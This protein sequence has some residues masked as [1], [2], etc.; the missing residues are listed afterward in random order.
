MAFLQD[1]HNVFYASESITNLSLDLTY[2]IHSA[3]QSANELLFLLI[4]TL[5]FPVYRGKSSKTYRIS[6]FTSVLFDITQRSEFH[7]GFPVRSLSPALLLT[8]PFIIRQKLLFQIPVLVRQKDPFLL[9]FYRPYLPSLADFY[10]G[11]TILV[12]ILIVN[13]P[14]RLQFL[15]TQSLFTPLSCFLT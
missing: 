2:K 4:E 12:A 13:S 10:S 5:G 14:S 7:S 1:T 9:Q 6:F 8:F 15:D 3:F 11:L